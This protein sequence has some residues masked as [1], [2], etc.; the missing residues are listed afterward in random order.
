MS[1]LAPARPRGH[2]DVRQYS[3]QRIAAG[4]SPPAAS[5]KAPSPHTPDERHDAFA[6]L[7]SHARYQILD[8]LASRPK[9]IKE[10][11]QELRLHRI[12]VRYHLT[13]LLREGFVEEAPV[14]RRGK[15]GRPASLYQTARHA[16]IPGFP[17]RHF[18]L[19]AQAALA[20]LLEALGE[21]DA[22]HRLYDKGKALGAGVVRGIAATKNVKKW[23]PSA[24]DEHVL[25]G[26]YREMG[27]ST[28][29]LAASAN[30]IEYRAFSCPFLELA[31]QMPDVVCDALDS[32][33][34]DGMDEAL[35]GALTTRRMCMGH[36]D[37]YC[38]YV[39]NWPPPRSVPGKGPETPAAPK[40]GAGA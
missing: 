9:T 33:F 21:G 11:T 1:A 19:I 8:A 26:S 10:L 16:S 6:A 39:V 25:R 7:A 15:A 28:E 23:T 35:G 36:G 4:G 14:L 22:R 18:E 40:K 12:T 27:V 17:V 2:R 5:A 31:E 3:N 30:T 20:A 24:F 34:H 13:F 38:E 32:G 29:V 37:L